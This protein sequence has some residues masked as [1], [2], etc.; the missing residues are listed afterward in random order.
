M[1]RT[2]VHGLHQFA[3][4][5]VEQLDAGGNDILRKILIR[6]EQEIVLGAVVAARTQGQVLL[7]VGETKD[8]CVYLRY[9]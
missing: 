6:G 9:F 5:A 7:G 1:T 4:G 2:G 8:S 3:G